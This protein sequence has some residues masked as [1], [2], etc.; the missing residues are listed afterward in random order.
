VLSYDYWTRQYARSPSVLGR[1]VALNGELYAIAGVM[2][3]GF[4]GVQPGDDPDLYIPLTQD[5]H[6]GAFGNT[7]AKGQPMLVDRHHWWLTIMGRLKPGVNRKQAQASLGINF[8][9]SVAAL[10]KV[11]LKPDQKP[12]FIVADGS[13]GAGE[14]RSYESEPL[15]ILMGIVCLLLL[16]ACANVAA[17]LLAR[18][19]TRGKEI[20][21]RL[22]LGAS[23]SRLIRQL[24]TESV[25][26]AAIGGALGLLAAY[27][28]ARALGVWLIQSGGM[29]VTWDISPDVKVLAF[30]AAVSVLT[31]ILFG[32]AP[33]FRATRVDVTPTLNGSGVSAERGGR[34]LGLGKGWAT[35][36]VAISLVL[37]IGAGLFVR[38]LNN[39]E[40]QDF[41]FNPRHLLI[42]LISA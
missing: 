8:M 28:G 24:L 34:G 30:T 6:V 14:V 18:A 17:L 26:M 13:G 41:G 3:K 33:A 10:Q 25:I 36:Q 31:G 9:Q 37:L 42:L 11:P 38:T 32:L 39:L 29:T 19:A 2:P 16:V 5:P 22:A 21:M 12:R 35:A 7:A 4:F 1:T 27:W 23:R 20:A 15:F 40:H